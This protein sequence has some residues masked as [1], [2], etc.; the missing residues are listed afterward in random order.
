MQHTIKMALWALICLCTAFSMGSCAHG[1]QS[2]K[3]SLYGDLK[4][5]PGKVYEV[6]VSEY[7]GET[8]LY[9][10]CETKAAH[11]ELGEGPGGNV[12]TTCIDTVHYHAYYALIPVSKD[13]GTFLYPITIY[14]YAPIQLSESPVDTFG[15]VAY[16]RLP[17]ECR[18]DISDV[19]QYNGFG[20][21][22]FIATV[23]QTPAYGTE[24]ISSPD[25]HGNQGP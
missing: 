12:I 10:Q 8:T 24:T 9:N 21:Y 19:F 3:E 7:A 5:Y 20:D 22:T 25:T 11:H 18:L 2:E 1:K 17:V 23:D 14:S 6:L 15:N 16:N 13:D 4:A